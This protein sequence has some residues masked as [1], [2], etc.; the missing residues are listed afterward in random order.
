[1]A[2]VMVA[3]AALARAV[4]GKMSGKGDDEMK[5]DED[6]DEDVK[7]E[8]GKEG[9]KEEGLLSPKPKKEQVDSTND[10]AKGHDA[11]REAGIVQENKDDAGTQPNKEEKTDEAVTQTEEEMV[12]M[13]LRRSDEEQ[14]E[15]DW[16]QLVQR[17]SDLF[18]AF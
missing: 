9:P 15:E 11:K 14:T 2:D 4:F 6:K 18:E 7:R 1:M 16:V 12:R 8:E 10:G 3:N 13:A 5:E 17:Q